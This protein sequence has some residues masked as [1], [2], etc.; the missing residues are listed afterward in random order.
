LAVFA[1]WW[2]S[3]ALAAAQLSLCQLTAQDRIWIITAIV[4]NSITFNSGAKV[5]IEKP[6][7]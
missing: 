7:K 1:F 6:T 2:L 3:D 4:S 5:L